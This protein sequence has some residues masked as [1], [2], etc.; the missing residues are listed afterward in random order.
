MFLMSSVKKPLKLYES[1][2][3]KLNKEENCYQASLE[4]KYK[5][6]CFVGVT[7]TEFVAR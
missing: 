4:Y 6:Y 3:I 5:K 7:V 2:N 1:K